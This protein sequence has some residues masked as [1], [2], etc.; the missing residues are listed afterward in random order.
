MIALVI[1][2]GVIGVVAAAL[3]V[4]SAGRA[5]RRWMQ[6]RSVARRLARQRLELRRSLMRRWW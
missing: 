5:L 6:W 1:A 3:A 4:V 2:A